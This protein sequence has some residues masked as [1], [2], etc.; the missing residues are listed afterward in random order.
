VGRH[1]R[2]ILDM[3]DQ[4]K[5]IDDLKQALL[6]ARQDIDKLSRVKTEFISIISHELR[7]PL[8]SIKESIALVIDGVTGPL[9]EEQR[10]FLNISRNNVDRLARLISDILDFS[11]LESGGLATHK[12]KVDV[13]EVVRMV[14]DAVKAGVQEKGLTLEMDLLKDAEPTWLDPDRIGQVIK[15]LI[16]NA[17]KFNKPGGRIKISTSKSDMSDKEQIK[18]TVEDTGI[19]IAKEEAGRL[20]KKFSPLDTSMTRK[21]GGAGLGLAISKGMIELHGGEMWVESEKDVGSKFMFTLPIYREDQEFDFLVEESIDRARYNQAS[22][23]LIVFEIKNE[24]ERSED[25][26]LKVENVIRMTVRGPEDKVIRYGEGHLLVLMAGTDRPGAMA[27]IK[28]LKSGMKVTALNFGVA[29]YPDDGLDGG[30][31]MKKA[32]SDLG[33]GSN[34]IVPRKILL[35]IDDEEDLASMLS[36]RLKGM[37][38]NTLTAGDGEKGLES[39]GQAKPDIILLDLM[40]PNVDGF[41]VCR[42]LKEKEDTRDIPILVFTALRKKN[43]EESLRKSGAADFIEKPFEPDDLLKKINKVIGGG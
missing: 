17:V 38:F 36:F 10:K 14:C 3:D 22:L 7:T 6:K 28:R 18:I 33:T 9:N 42:R 27:I 5:E 43:L 35:I 1:T 41:E 29:V 40:M 39:A 25:I 21:H 23:S 4:K 32:V 37:G 30:A 16:S 11:K 24:R 31:L 15:S 20:F 13:N 34:S 2:Q 8:T 12:K 19:G 26:F